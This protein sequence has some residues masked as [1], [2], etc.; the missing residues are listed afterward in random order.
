MKVFHFPVLILL[1][2][3]LKLSAQQTDQV[4]RTIIVSKNGGGDFTEIQEA[5]NS[6][7]DLGPG[8]V[9]I[10]IRN[11]IYNEKVEIPTWKHKLRLIGEHREKTIIVNDDYSG[12][13]DSTSGKIH[14]TFSSFTLLVSGDEIELEN[15]TLTNN[16][17]GEG[18]AVAL[19]VEGDKFVC[20][21]VKLLGCQDTLYAA[22][23]NSRQFYKNCYIEG[24]T[25]FIFGEA[26]AVFENCEI[27]SL[28]NSFITAAAT[29]PNQ[30]F[31]FV[32]LN[33][34]LTA[35]EEVSKVYLGRPWRP[36]AKTVFINS[37]FGSH[38]L[39]AGWD[40]WQGDKMFPDKEKTAFYAEYNNSGPGAV[41][42]KRVKWSMQ[43]DAKEAKTFTMSNIF[44]HKDNWNP[45]E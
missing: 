9:E 16:S 8:F 12:K 11:G 4:Y 5:I 39:S 29:S 36:Y 40:A 35:A 10:K 20:K 23:R 45:T 6:T 21:N 32:F 3:G 27:K 28:K 30:E 43:L 26:T 34:Q 25:D 19:H 41:S 31:G 38:I 44:K 2:L 37:E 33:C 7:R 17:C 18:Q 15:L 13:Q 1:V 42:S 14:S 24:T 22:K